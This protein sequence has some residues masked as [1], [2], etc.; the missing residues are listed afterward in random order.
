MDLS[1]IR[2]RINVEDE[3]QQ[4]KIGRIFEVRE[5]IA[6]EKAEKMKTDI[7]NNQ[8]RIYQIQKENERRRKER[9]LRMLSQSD[10]LG[11]T[12]TSR[13]NGILDSP[14]KSSFLDSKNLNVLDEYNEKTYDTV[15]RTRAISAEHNLDLDGQS[16]DPYAPNRMYKREQKALLQDQRKLTTIKEVNDKMKGRTDNKSS[17]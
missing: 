15:S 10:R 12:G 7:L 4:S 11:Q 8:M 13:S 1:N 16:I 9:H 14:D 3:K 2:S 17:P 6:Q 5:K